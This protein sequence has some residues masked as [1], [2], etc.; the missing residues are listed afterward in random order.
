[1]C[2]GW[3]YLLSDAPNNFYELSKF[4]NKLKTEN[5]LCPIQPLLVGLRVKLHKSSCLRLKFS[6]PKTIVPKS[7]LGKNQ[8]REK[9]QKVTYLCKIYNSNSINSYFRPYTPHLDPFVPK[10]THI[11]AKILDFFKHRFFS[12]FWP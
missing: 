11:V 7:I 12:I 8:L 4:K 6:Y 9:A 5:Q 10:I 3:W 1:M 2:Q